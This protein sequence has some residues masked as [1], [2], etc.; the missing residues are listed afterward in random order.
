MAFLIMYPAVAVL[1]LFVLIVIILM[2]RFGSRWC[3]LR[4]T[5]F[6]DQEYWTEE[7]AYEQKVSY[8]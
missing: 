7:E 6:A 4:H 8:A 1:T 3:K 2:L 5:A